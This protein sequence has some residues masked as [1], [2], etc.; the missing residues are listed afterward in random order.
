MQWKYGRGW[1]DEANELTIELA[2]FLAGITVEEGGL[3]KYQ[4]CRNAIDLLW[5]YEG[6]AMK[7]DWHPWAERMIE[8]VCENKYL[9][10]AGCAS[11]GKSD[12]FAVYG[13]VCFIA[14]PV[15]TRVLVTSTTLKDSRLR[16]WGRI[17]EYWN[18][19]PG[20]PGKL[21]DSQGMIKYVDPE[22]GVADESSGIVLIAGESK[23]EKE[24]IKKLI[25]F[26]RR[27]VIVLADEL[28]ELSPTILEA[29]LSNLDSN[30]FFQ[31]VGIGNPNSRFD[32]HGVF[33]K[34]KDGWGSVAA[35][36]DEWETD[37]GKCI[38]FDA[39]L[40]PNITAG[41]VLYP[42]L[43]T[44]EK[45]A[46]K[47]K[48]LGEDSL[49][50]WRMFRGFWCPTGSAAGIYS[51]ADITQ[52][53]A[54]ERLVRWTT[55]A[56]RIA[57]I[58]TSFTAGGDRAM[59]Y[60]G[61]IGETMSGSKVLVYDSEGVVI[62]ESVGDP[63]GF[64]FQVAEKFRDLCKKEQ[65]PVNCVGLDVTGG[66]AP[67]AD[68]LASVWGAGFH[69]VLFSGSASSKPVSATDPRPCNEVYANRVSELWGIGVQYIRTGQLKGIGKALAQEMVSRLYTTGNKGV[70]EVE[71]KRKM[72]ARTG[73][74]P[75]EADAAFGL[76][77]LARERFSF[78]CLEGEI[79]QRR[80]SEEGGTSM[81]WDDF[82]SAG[83]RTYESEPSFDPGFMPLQFGR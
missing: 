25:G 7:F 82:V 11:S 35:T 18:A 42:Y 71:S 48:E 5:N 79:I 2:A 80:A 16:I 39:E 24:S 38:R 17:K 6:S 1:E 23:K 57:F 68:I 73:K 10:V 46:A 76:L 36:A 56:D 67:F 4:H 31:L 49:L 55:I 81:T 26:K 69:R 50:Y 32:A 43:C 58:D 52:F 40:S 64:S 66:G 45:L 47:K 75:D 77:D 30:P 33:S 54:D 63:K 34:P 22:T 60:F 13:I 53:G 72:K 59:A 62:S 21:V 41:K 78:D 12:T 9:S 61:W 44:E 28:P 51:E 65:I 70:I 15:N 19:I 14:D 20:A 29:A 74:S 83:D 3:G 27:R 8:E 37:Y